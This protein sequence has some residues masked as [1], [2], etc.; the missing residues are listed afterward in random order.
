MFATPINLTRVCQSYIINIKMDVRL[1]RIRLISCSQSG[2]MNLSQ[3]INKG[4]V[5]SEKNGSCF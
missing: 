5:G 3:L 2:E 1:Q 4:I